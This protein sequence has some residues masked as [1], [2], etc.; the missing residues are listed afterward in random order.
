MPLVRNITSDDLGFAGLVV[1]AGE[2]VEV[3]KNMAARMVET[4][5][6]KFRMARKAKN[7]SMA[8]SKRAKN[9]AAS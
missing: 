7:R 1:P 5:P 3:S 4:L 9:R 2:A 8:G 6:D